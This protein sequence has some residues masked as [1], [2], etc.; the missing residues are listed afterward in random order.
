VF[1]DEFL[2]KHILSLNESGEIIR[3]GFSLVL[4][5]PKPYQDLVDFCWI[6]SWY[7][8]ALAGL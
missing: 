2:K 7:Y 1:S 8:G 5:I 3:S 6:R 4:P